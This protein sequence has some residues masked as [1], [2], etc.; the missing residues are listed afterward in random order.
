MMEHDVEPIRGLPGELPEGE[1]IL[2]RGAPEWRSFARRTL[3]TRTVAYYFAA[4]MALRAIVAFEQGDGALGALS[5][6]A[7]LLPLGLAAVGAL[8]LIGYVMAKTS[9]Y[10]VT[11]QRVVLRIG[12]ALTLCANVPFS[13]IA[14]A[15]AKTYAD[16]TGEISLALSGS[17]KFSYLVLWP[18]ARPWRFNHPEPMLRAVPNAAEVAELLGEALR[19]AAEARDAVPPVLTREDRPEDRS[20]AA[21]PRPIDP[22]AAPDFAQA[23]AVGR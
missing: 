16:G 4:L 20:H 19:S 14:S 13:R 23:S 6:A 15:D 22:A 21:E 2:W 3:L 1:R 12:V 5:A 17:D 10:T 8:A 9:V 18:H 11:N 7:G